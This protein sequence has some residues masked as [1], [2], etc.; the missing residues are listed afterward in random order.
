M[1]CWEQNAALCRAQ[2]EGRPAAAL[3]A[4]HRELPLPP[5]ITGRT[6]STSL[7]ADDARRW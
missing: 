2:L 1:K 6:S 4:L 3:P 5:D 7:V